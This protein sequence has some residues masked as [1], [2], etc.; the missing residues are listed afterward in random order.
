MVVSEIA[1]VVVEMGVVVVILTG[2]NSS[3]KKMIDERYLL[4]LYW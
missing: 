4:H 3:E 1:V 2:T